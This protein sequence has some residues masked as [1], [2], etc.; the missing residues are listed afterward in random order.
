MGNTPAIRS[1]W[2]IKPLVIGALHLPD[3]AVARET[4]LATLER[5]VL[6]N[7]AAF[8]SGGMQ[9]LIL[10]DQTRSSGG[11]GPETIA[12][13]G[14]LGRL[15]RQTFP[16]LVLGIIMRAHDATAPLAVAHAVGA[17]FV[18]IKVYVGGVMSAE[19]PLD[20]LGVRARAYRHDIR[21]DD[22]AIIADVHDRTTYP[23]DGVPQTEAALW[24]E[25]LGA[26]GLIL[27]GSAFPDS[28]A[29]VAAAREAGVR[30]PILIGG[31]VNAG[32]IC[33]ALEASSGV[34][35]SRSLMCPPDADGVRWHAERIRTL[36]ATAASVGRAA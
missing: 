7:A 9:A 32:N 11:A 1:I 24:A 15:L 16:D 23:R 28:V 26:D 12:I 31:G 27:T 29:R 22:I 14:S 3:L 10:Q 18:R 19:G 4:S 13:M 25:R 5:Y 36:V 8:V 21:R 6:H 2:D 17:S 34:I 20:G 35:V 33:T 30:V